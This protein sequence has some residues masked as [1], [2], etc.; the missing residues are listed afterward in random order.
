MSLTPCAVEFL[1]LWVLLTIM[2]ETLYENAVVNIG[3]EPSYRP[4]GKPHPVATLRS[5]A[6]LRSTSYPPISAINGGPPFRPR[7]QHA[8][9]PFVERL[10]TEGSRKAGT[11]PPEVLNRTPG[12]LQ[13]RDRK[14]FVGG[15]EKP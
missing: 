10:A 7:C 2:Q 5:S 3:D 12:A 9:A 11:L 4:A 13:R 1:A 8:L 15:S 6:S 14:E